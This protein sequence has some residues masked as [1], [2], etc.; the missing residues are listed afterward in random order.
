MDKGNYVKTRE[1]TLPCSFTEIELHIC[2]KQ[3][4]VI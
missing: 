1:D 4:V 3:N 2:K